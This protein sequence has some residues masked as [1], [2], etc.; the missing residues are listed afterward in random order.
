[1]VGIC[2]YFF[3]EAVKLFLERMHFESHQQYRRDPLLLH[4]C[5][6]LLLSLFFIL[7]LLIGV[8]WNLAVVLICIFLMANDIEHLFMC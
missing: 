3:L 4:P 1:M 8:A 6:H 5:Q 2:F 7:A